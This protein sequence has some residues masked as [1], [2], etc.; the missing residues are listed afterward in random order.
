MLHKHI[1][2]Q[3]QSPPPVAP[4]LTV[5]SHTVFGVCLGPLQRIGEHLELKIRHTAQSTFTSA[6]RRPC[7]AQGL[8]SVKNAGQCHVHG[9]STAQLPAVLKSTCRAED[10]GLG[11]DVDI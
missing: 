4:A 7:T 10:A 5:R 9:A 6:V 11:S 2:N 1:Q 8:V 3:V